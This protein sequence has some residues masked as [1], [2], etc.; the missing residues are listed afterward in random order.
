MAGDIVNVIV[1]NAGKI[2][3]RSAKEQGQVWEKVAEA[4]TKISSGI[5]KSVAAPASP[6]SLQLSLEDDDLKKTAADYAKAMKRLIEENERAIGYVAVI[7]DSV[8]GAE[9][10]AGH[11]LFRRLWPKLIETTAIEAI[12]EKK[13]KQAAKAATVEDVKEFLEKAEAVPASAEKIHG[14]FWSI[15]A[16]SKDTAVFQ[17]VDKSKG[18]LWL[19]RSVLK[20]QRAIFSACATASN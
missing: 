7:N 16:V 11:D 17:T 1:G 18:G 10:F 6:I 8:H 13:D 4:Q 3:V 2:A 15:S 14:D 5:S 9:I 12:S 20:K 19:R